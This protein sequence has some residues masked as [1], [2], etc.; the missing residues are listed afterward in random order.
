[1]RFFPAFLGA[2]LLTVAIF[3]FMQSLIERGKEEGVQL[4]IYSNVEILRPKP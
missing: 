2:L 1:M 4:A 3:L